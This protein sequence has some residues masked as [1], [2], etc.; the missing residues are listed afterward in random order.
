[1]LELT[2][3]SYQS[4]DR[5]TKERVVVPSFTLQL[6]HSLVAISKWESK[7]E[8]PF[9]TNDAKS[10]EEII[11]YTRCM[12]LNEDV[13][14]RV[15]NRLSV[16]D[17]HDISEYISKKHTATW[18]SESEDK[19]VGGDNSVITS[20]VIYYWMVSLGIPFECETWNLN[21]LITLVRVI[22][23]KNQPPKKMNRTD[24]MARAR[25]LNRQRKAELKTRG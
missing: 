18:F 1:M 6:E 4:Y 10:E 25:A 17:I 23:A 12:T 9:L 2:I 5:E 7:Y 16:E 22:N 8:K 15:F 24:A 19:S 13:P 14:D 20:E 3:A 21:R 11:Y